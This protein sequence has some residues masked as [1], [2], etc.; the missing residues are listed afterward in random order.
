MTLLQKREKEK[1]LCQ[2][3]FFS[4]IR[5]WM[6]HKHIVIWFNSNRID[7][8]TSGKFENHQSSD[9]V[10]IYYSESHLFNTWA[11]NKSFDSK[12][13]HHQHEATIINNE[14]FSRRWLL[15]IYN[16]SRLTISASNN[17]IVFVRIWSE[18]RFSLSHK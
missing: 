6:E 16:I 18:W 17:S 3:I 14:N 10:L 15:F 5:L 7:F 8:V 4:N 12:V 1:L 11:A 13:H 9:C 2:W